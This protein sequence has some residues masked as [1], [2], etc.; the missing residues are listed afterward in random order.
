MRMPRIS[1]RSRIGA[2]AAALALA[3]GATL[4]MASPAWADPANK[5]AY[6][7]DCGATIYHV[8]SPDHAATGSAVNSTSQLIAVI[9]KVLQRLATSC[10]ATN[11]ARENSC[12][13]DQPTDAPIGRATRASLSRSQVAGRAGRAVARLTYGV[14]SIVVHWL[15]SLVMAMV[16]HLVTQ[17]RPDQAVSPSLSATDVALC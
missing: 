1:V 9:G 3:G 10:T 16:T 6:T 4:A 17:L 7:L 2:A 5:P 11:D 14:M 12:A 13:R 8:V 15:P